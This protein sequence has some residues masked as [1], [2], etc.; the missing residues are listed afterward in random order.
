[1]IKEIWFIKKIHETAM[2]SSNFI[3]RE[4]KNYITIWRNKNLG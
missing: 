1:M 4:T 3:R 2:S